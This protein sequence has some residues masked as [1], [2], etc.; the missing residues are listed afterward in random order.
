MLIV[1]DMLGKNMLLCSSKKIM[2][3]NKKKYKFDY[4]I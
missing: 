2:K 3:S 1:L 4:L